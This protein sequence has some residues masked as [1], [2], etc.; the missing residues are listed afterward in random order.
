MTSTQDDIASTPAEPTAAHPPVA[1]STR[2]GD[3]A[4]HPVS[5]DD[6]GHSS[7]SPSGS[8]SSE[9]DLKPQNSR[10]QRPRM[11]SRKSSG[12]IIVPRESEYIELQEEEYDENDARTMSPRRTSDEIEQMTLDAR[13]TMERQAKQLQESLLAV[14]EKVESVKNEH[15][16]LEGGNKFLQSYVGLVLATPLTACLL[17]P[18]DRYIGELMQTSKIASSG[19]ARKK[20][21]GRSTK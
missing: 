2:D 17:T 12:T 8:S 19:P 7:T 16:K 18:V 4:T 14:V 13:L 10:L 21:K 11:G 3:P 9:D 1:P 6:I 5:S 20:G 15:E